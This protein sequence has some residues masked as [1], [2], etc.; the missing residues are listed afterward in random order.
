MVI[1]AILPTKEEQEVLLEH[2]L[3]AGNAKAHA[4]LLYCHGQSAFQISQVLF[5]TEKTVREWIKNF[6]QER[7]TSIFTKA[8]G[9]QNAAKLT[10]AQKQQLAEVLAKPPSDYGIPAKFWSISPLRRYVYAEWGVEYESDESYRLIFKLANYSW[11]LPGK[12]NLL[13]DETAI[14]ARME[15]IMAEIEPLLA[16]ET[17][18]VLAADETRVV[19]ETLLRRAWLPKGQKTI[20]RTSMTKS[21]QSFFG[22]L[23]LKS[24]R[25]HTFAIPWQNQTQM[26]RVLKKLKRVYSEKRLCLVWD[27][28]R[29]HKGKMLRKNLER[30]QALSGIHLINFYPYAPDTNPQEKVWKWGKD[31]VA[32]QTY[33]TLADLSQKFLRIVTGRS[34]PYQI[35]PFVL[36]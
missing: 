13:R 22:A 15:E 33:P 9:N 26:I 35:T 27:N 31:Q 11:K 34:Y 36:G 25:E 3:K 21:G 17:W 32:N 16:D 10:R 7:L 29:W 5:R 18:E 19:W 30:G 8:L 12:F 14:A 2:Y 6:G 20:I 4:I 28:A 1:S 24:G 23:N